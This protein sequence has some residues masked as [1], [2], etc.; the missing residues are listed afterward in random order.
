MTTFTQ[1][2][3][4]ELVSPTNTIQL[5]KYIRREPQL[6][7]MFIKIGHFTYIF[8]NGVVGTGYENYVKELPKTYII[9]DDPAGAF[10]EHDKLTNY[11]FYSTSKP[12]VELGKFLRV[13]TEWDD[14]WSY[15]DGPSQTNY[16]YFENNKNFMPYHL[17]FIKKVESNANV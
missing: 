7:G 13:Q 4:Y 12:P 15:R 6:E 8:D 17:Q 11:A 10:S 5:G 2:T 14:N 3:E 9:P 16:Y 1:Y